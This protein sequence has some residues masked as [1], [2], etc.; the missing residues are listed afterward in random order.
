[1][2]TSEYELP[3]PT[4]MG[5][6]D[7]EWQ[8]RRDSPPTMKMWRDTCRHCF[9]ALHGKVYSN[10]EW[11]TLITGNRRLMSVVGA[12]QAGEQARL[13]ENQWRNCYKNNH[14]AIDK[15]MDDDPVF[16]RLMT[17]MGIGDK[18]DAPPQKKGR[19]TFYNRQALYSQVAFGNACKQ[20]ALEGRSFGHKMIDD[21]IDTYKGM[22]E[23]SLKQGAALMMDSLD[24]FPIKFTTGSPTGPKLMLLYIQARLSPHERMGYWTPISS[25]EMVWVECYTALVPCQQGHWFCT[26]EG[27]NQTKWRSGANGNAIF[28]NQGADGQGC[29]LL[30]LAVPDQDADGNFIH[31]EDEN[32][33]LQFLRICQP[34]KLNKVALD[35]FTIMAYCSEGGFKADTIFEIWQ[36]ILQK[37]KL[38]NEAVERFM[39]PIKERQS[40]L[41]GAESTRC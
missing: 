25:G 3:V 14:K 5:G 4:R 22:I 15:K 10:T 16:R 28:Q 39:T 27:G 29:C 37:L 1:M 7:G 30:V 13:F 6:P 17:E 9:Q 38:S 12:R 20:A 23:G 24:W 19:S 2:V 41:H 18:K 31:T 11:N 35:I 26:K 32:M 21:L 8:T 40:P 36:N 34:D 33:N